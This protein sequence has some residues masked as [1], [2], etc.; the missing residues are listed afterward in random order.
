MVK[1]RLKKNKARL[2]KKMVPRP[3][4]SFAVWGTILLYAFSFSKAHRKADGVL[5]F[6]AG[7]EFGF[8][9]LGDGLGDGE[10]YA[11]A[12]ALAGAGGVGAI[13]AFEEAVEVAGGDIV[14][15]VGDLEQGA[16]AAAAF[17]AEGDGAGFAAYLMALSVRMEMSGEASSLPS[18]RRS[19][20]ISSASCTPL[21]SGQ[22]AKGSGG[23][24]DGCASGRILDRL[25]G[26]PCSFHLGHRQQIADEA[27]Q[28]GG[29][30]ANAGQPFAGAIF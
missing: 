10:A 19:G 24:H 23:I 3:Q 1:E 4:T 12:A 22:G 28:A 16:A 20:W 17:E 5:V 6:A 15:A 30:A 25:A 13:E 26:S 18:S 14:A 7:G 29:L 21:A 2:F 27:L 9:G 11:V 8:V